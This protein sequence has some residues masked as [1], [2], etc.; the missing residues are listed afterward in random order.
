MRVQILSVKFPILRRNER[1]ILLNVQICLC[2]VQVIFAEL[3]ETEL[4]YNFWKIFKYKFFSNREL[5]GT[6]TKSVATFLKFEKACNIF[7]FATNLKDSK[8]CN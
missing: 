1:V 2:N 7:H 8:P 4:L 6:M 5:M 3:F